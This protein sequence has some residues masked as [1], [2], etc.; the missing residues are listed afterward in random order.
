[1][2]FAIGQA[3]GPGGAYAWRFEWVD[4]VHIERQVDPARSAQSFDGFGHR[5]GNA[6]LIDL[7]HREHA[8]AKLAN[9]AAFARIERSGAVQHDAF[10]SNTA[11]T[12]IEPSPQA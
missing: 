1:M 3:A 4:G 7:G 9:Q 5:R 12:P 10:G 6:A 11:F 2:G 8:N